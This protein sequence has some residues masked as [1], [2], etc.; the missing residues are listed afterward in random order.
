MTVPSKSPS[1]RATSASAAL[2]WMTTGLPSLGDREVRLKE[3]A[4]R[5]VRRVVAE[6]VEARFAHRDRIELLVPRLRGLCFLATCGW[7][8]RTGKTFP[9]R[10][11]SRRPGPSGQARRRPRGCGRRPPAGRGRPTPREGLRTQAGAHAC[12]SRSGGRR[13]DAWKERWRRFDVLRLDGLARRDRGPLE[14]L[15]LAECGGCAASSPADTRAT[16]RR[17]RGCRRRARRARGSA[18]PRLRRPWPAPTASSRSRTCSARGRRPRSRRL[19][20]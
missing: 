15:G 16:R 20:R 17:R 13:L 3:L 6:V 4:L 19:R 8:P 7:I 10:H 14:V 5:I 1:A 18:L 9:S 12:R 2:Q 11:R